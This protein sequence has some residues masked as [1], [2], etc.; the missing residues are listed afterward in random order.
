MR[1]L[2]GDAGGFSSGPRSS[3]ATRPVRGYSAADVR[4]GV[5]GCPVCD[6]DNVTT[7]LAWAV[8]ALD[9]ELV[10]AARRVLADD[11]LK[12]VVRVP[13]LHRRQA[14]RQPLWGGELV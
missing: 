10:H 4:C 9:A 1:S 3:G 11:G 8:G 7:Y 5:N 14:V 2:S 6:V 12:D 13:G